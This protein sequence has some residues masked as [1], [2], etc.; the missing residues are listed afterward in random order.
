[1]P[2]Y[3]SCEGVSPFSCGGA[4]QC[5][6]PDYP[7]VQEACHIVAN[8]TCRPPQCFA[9][10]NKGFAF[11]DSAESDGQ[12][13]PWDHALPAA[14]LFLC[15]CVIY[16]FLYGAGLSGCVRIEWLTQWCRHSFNRLLGRLGLYVIILWRF[17]SKSGAEMKTTEA[18]HCAICLAE[19]KPH[20]HVRLLPCP[21]APRGHCFHASCVDEWLLNSRRCPL[22]KAYYGGT[23][24]RHVGEPAGDSYYSSPGSSRGYRSPSSVDPLPL[25][26]VT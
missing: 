4:L 14:H 8:A 22:C 12:C 24:M 19:W 10:C 1:M 15:F 17:P 18:D 20:D 25:L 21:S 23:F 5:L 2:V 9:Y 11:Y 3:T 7:G 6:S 16:C 13:L 26:T